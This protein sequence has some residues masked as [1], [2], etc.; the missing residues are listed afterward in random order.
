MWTAFTLKN[1]LCGHM[2]WTPFISVTAPQWEEIYCHW[3]LKRG[4]QRK[5]IPEDQYIQKFHEFHKLN[6]TLLPPFPPSYL[7]HIWN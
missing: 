3:F 6:K 2:T 7:T 5:Q 1:L 4:K